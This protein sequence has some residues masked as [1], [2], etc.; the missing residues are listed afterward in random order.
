[1]DQQLPGALRAG[2]DPGS[3]SRDHGAAAGQS[4]AGPGRAAVAISR[5]R[6]ALH[7]ADR[8]AGGDVRQRALVARDGGQRTL[9]CTVDGRGSAL[10]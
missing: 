3:R 7:D 8:R 2:A 1:M 10:D 5:R 6:A 9:L 4:S